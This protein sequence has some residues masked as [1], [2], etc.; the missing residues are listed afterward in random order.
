MAAG[1]HSQQIVL[2]QADGSHVRV[3]SKDVARL[4]PYGLAWQP[5]P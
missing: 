3:L 1:D 2:M 4:I 5:V